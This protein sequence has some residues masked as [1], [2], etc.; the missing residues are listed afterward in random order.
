MCHLLLQIAGI[1]FPLPILLLI[2][3]RQYLL[4]RVFGRANLATLDPAVYE[5]EGGNPRSE[6]TFQQGSQ[7]EM[8]SNGAAAPRP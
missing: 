4:P 1:V 6:T 7:V 5:D 3:V 2:P 8:Q